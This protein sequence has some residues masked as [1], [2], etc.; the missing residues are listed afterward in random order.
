[1]ITG[2]SCIR[3]VCTLGM[4]L[5]AAVAKHN[6]SKAPLVKSFH[7]NAIGAI[8]SIDMKCQIIRIVC[9]HLLLIAITVCNYTHLYQILLFAFMCT[10]WQNHQWPED[11]DTWL[12]QM[13][14]CPELAFFIT[15][16][17]FASAAIQSTSW[18]CEIFIWLFC[19]D[20]Y[21]FG[22]HPPSRQA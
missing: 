13:K 17:D 10:H 8:G 19:N 22:T 16:D 6:L 3:R 2:G 21:L 20:S 14:E 9:C 7:W 1:M 12:V 4:R 11:L 18:L 5:A 15:I